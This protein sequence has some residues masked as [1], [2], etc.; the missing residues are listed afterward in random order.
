MA[1]VRDV[2]SLDDTELYLLEVVPLVEA[3][4]LRVVPPGLRP[5][6]DSAVQGLERCLHVVG[7]RRRDHSREGRPLWSVSMFLLVP[8]F[9]LSVGFG[10]VFFPRE[11][12]SPS[13][14]PATATSI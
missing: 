3:E 12:P 10:P 2:L 8:S 14:S 9:A 7:V 4:V 6:Y 5:P 13:S 11:A 1:H